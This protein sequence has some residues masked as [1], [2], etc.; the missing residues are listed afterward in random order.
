MAE[1]DPTSDSDARSDVRARGLERMN[2]VYGWTLPEVEGDFV[3]LTVDHL[4]AEI[5]NRPG[6]SIRDRRLLLIGMLVGSG[7][8]DVLDIQL[9]SALSQ[10]DLTPEDLR[11]IVIF[12]AH[13][14]GWPRGARCN[15]VVERAIGRH[16][17]RSG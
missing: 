16:Q 15:S 14:A 4:F 3:A 7:Q 8:E 6:L 17:G 10:G 9:P 5:W 12:V 1:P 11:E 2:E 13:Y